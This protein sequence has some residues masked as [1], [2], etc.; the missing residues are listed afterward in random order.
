MNL[1]QILDII[2]AIA[3][4]LSLALVVRY[5]YAWLLYTCSS[6]G[7]TYVVYCRNLPGQT[8]MGCILTCVGIYNYW[9]SEERF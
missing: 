9:L 8:V 3:T 4:P 2:C 6:I 7:F 1:V 5:R